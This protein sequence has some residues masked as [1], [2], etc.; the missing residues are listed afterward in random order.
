MLATSENIAGANVDGYVRRAPSVRTYGLS[1]N[2]IDLTGTSFAVEGFSRFFDSHLQ[3]Q[4]LAQQSNSARS[5]T[6]LD[7]LSVLDSILTDPA[8]SLAATR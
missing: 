5:K 1:P 4:L 7:T 3:S 2:N 6:V 8:T